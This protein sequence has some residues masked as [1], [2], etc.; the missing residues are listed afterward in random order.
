M[1]QH[2]HDKYFMKDG[3]GKLCVCVCRLQRP[4]NR[5]LS[6]L[7]RVN[8]R[9]YSVVIRAF[10]MLKASD[11]TNLFTVADILIAATSAV[12]V[13]FQLVTI[14]ATW[15]F[16]RARVTTRAPSVCKPSLVLGA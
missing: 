2:T 10:R 13:S 7:L 4:I 8:T 1:I 15:Q 6:S 14:D 9:V 5:A 11:C 12:E 3:D 16:T